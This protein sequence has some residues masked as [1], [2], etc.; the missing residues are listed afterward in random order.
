[1]NAYDTILP[2]AMASAEAQYR[3]AERPT[4][5]AIARAWGTR[6]AL[7]TATRTEAGYTLPDGTVAPAVAG[8]RVT[9]ILAWENAALRARDAAIRAELGV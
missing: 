8:G 9:A 5:L 4:N 1:M 7:A 3:S 2:L 6:R